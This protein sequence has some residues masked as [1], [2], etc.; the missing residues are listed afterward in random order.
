MIEINQVRQITWRNVPKTVSEFL[1]LWHHFA[2]YQRKMNSDE[3]WNKTRLNK[4]LFLIISLFIVFKNKS[5]NCLFISKPTA[6]MCMAA[7][8]IA[9]HDKI[10][11]FFL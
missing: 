10:K 2:S 3:I 4:I 1:K 9:S 5:F 6:P 7:S 8:Y 11:V